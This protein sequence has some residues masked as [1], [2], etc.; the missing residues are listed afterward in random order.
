MVQ[1][2]Y[3]E[4]MILPY[5]WIDLT[6]SVL[7]GVKGGDVHPAVTPSRPRSNCVNEILA[8]GE[9]SLGVRGIVL[10][11]PLG[12]WKL[13]VSA[14]PPVFAIL[15]TRQVR[16]PPLS[17]V[18]LN[19][20]DVSGK[21]REDLREPLMALPRRAEAMRRSVGHR[22]RGSAL[23]FDDAAHDGSGAAEQSA[24]PLIAQVSG[25]SR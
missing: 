4:I 24:A 13:R 8:Y 11:H 22:L 25:S 3:D 2:T 9:S 6:L 16:P 18:W 23:L 10:K 15:T 20:D 19:F 5:R 14:R 21:I 17:Y 7:V 12:G 1:L